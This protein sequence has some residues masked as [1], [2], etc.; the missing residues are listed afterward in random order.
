MVVDVLSEHGHLGVVVIIARLHVQQLLDQF[1]GPGVFHVRLVH[2]VV[3]VDRRANCRIEDLFL[4]LGVDNEFH[5]DLL[6]RR[7]IE[8]YNRSLYRKALD[9]IG[10]GKEAKALPV[11]ND[12]IKAVGDRLSA[13]YDDVLARSAPSRIDTP[14]KTAL[15]K[16]EGMVPRAMRKDFADIIDNQVRARVTPGQT[17][18]PSV[19]QEVE[20]ELGRL[21]AGYRGS[22]TESERQLGRALQQAQEEVRALVERHNPVTAPELR[23]LRQG[24]SVLTQL[25]NAGAMLGAKEGI[26]TPSQFLNAVKKSDKSVRDRAF[27]RGTARNQEIAQAADAV[28]SQKYPE[29][30]TASRAMVGALAGTGLG[31]INPAIPAALGTGALAYT[32]I[33]QRATAAMLAQRP[34]SAKELGELLK[35]LSPYLGGPGAAGL[36][37]LSP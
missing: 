16:I 37:S 32:P 19:A 23:K 4:D 22:A 36:L 33:G 25:E 34:E 28:L 6:Q 15:T 5:A 24:W 9:P 26:F 30:G 27:A 17:L 7:A 8:E 35:R 3:V 18:P 1:L 29:S 21:A 20:S 2:Q 12:G 14:F 11:G 10:L 31:Y 13:A